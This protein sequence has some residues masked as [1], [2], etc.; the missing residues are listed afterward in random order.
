MGEAL[1]DGPIKYNINF[2]N[3][4][5]YRYVNQKFCPSYFHI[6]QLISFTV[7]GVTARMRFS[8][9]LSFDTGDLE[10]NLI[11]YPS[12]NVLLANYAP[13][14]FGKR[15]QSVK[16]ITNAVFNHG[17]FVGV[18]L[19]TSQFLCCALLYRGK[20][21]PLNISESICEMKRFVEFVPWMPTGFKVGVSTE[22]VRYQRDCVWDAP[23]RAVTKLA[24]HGSVVGLIRRIKERYEP[25]FDMKGFFH[26]FI[27]AG[28]EEGQ[29]TEAMEKADEV[30]AGYE[31]ALAA[32]SQE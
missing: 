11:P 8:G 17:E 23:V 21:S 9:D 4:S 1:V 19:L 30:M 25:T 31:A 18:D 10:T 15:R 26:H 12:L 6:N 14:N 20:C 16:A 5:L 2:D 32:S 24:N 22:R 3:Q 27:G 13:M 28:M 29:F 7:S